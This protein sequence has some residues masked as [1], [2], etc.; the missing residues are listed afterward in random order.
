MG[1]FISRQCRWRKYFHPFLASGK[2]DFG[3]KGYMRGIGQNANVTMKI[4]ST[5]ECMWNA[6][7]AGMV[8]PAFNVPYLP[9]M[10]PIVT[11]LPAT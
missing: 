10:E 6:R 3:E 5:Q 8:I 7:R 2:A 4:R 11:A 9:M 1:S